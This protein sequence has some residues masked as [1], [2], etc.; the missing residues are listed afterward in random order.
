MYG[1]LTISNFT[2]RKVMGGLKPLIRQLVRYRKYLD[3]SCCSFWMLFIC[4]SNK[5]VPKDRPP[6][7]K[8]PSR[9]VDSYKDTTKNKHNCYG[10][11]LFLTNKWWSTKLERGNS[12]IPTGSV[13]TFPSAINALAELCNFLFNK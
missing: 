4:S 9:S 8:K 7:E 10:N 13:A 1:N 2:L 3:I 11:V 12:K 5:D 6:F